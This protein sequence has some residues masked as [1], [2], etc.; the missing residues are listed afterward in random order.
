MIN[1]F[2]GAETLNTKEENN[3]DDRWNPWSS[4]YNDSMCLEIIEMFAQGKTAA[5]FCARHTIGA[6]TY[7]KWRR[8]HKLFDRAVIA[9]HEKARAYYD[10]LRQQYLVQ[11]HEGESINWG[12]FNRMYNARFNIPDKRQVTVKTLGKA[13][14]EREMLKAIMKAVSNGDLTPDE[15]QK[16]ASLID[17]SLMVKQSVELE[18]R[19][20]QIEEANSVGFD[21]AGFEEVTGDI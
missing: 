6:D 9:A 13:K 2:D 14:D 3:T 7:C 10:D 8:K 17:V 19:V 21:D 5:Q 1:K 11:E 4:K 16:L 12:L 20:S 18:K 15:A